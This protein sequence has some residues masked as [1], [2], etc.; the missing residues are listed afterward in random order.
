MTRVRPPRFGMGGQLL[1]GGEDASQQLRPGCRD[2]GGGPSGARSARAAATGPEGA[3]SRGR[4]RVCA[5][6]TRAASAVV[7]SRNRG[8]TK[9]ASLALKSNESRRPH[10]AAVLEREARTAVGGEGRGGLD[11]AALEALWSR[12]PNAAVACTSTRGRARARP[13]RH[14][15]DA[16][17]SERVECGLPPGARLL[18]WSTIIAPTS[19]ASTP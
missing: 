14:G 2:G 1:D 15:L 13:A 8:G 6:R 17:E 7:A 18:P 4:L 9:A 19:T 5:H 3:V 11:R 16:V 10:D 12:S